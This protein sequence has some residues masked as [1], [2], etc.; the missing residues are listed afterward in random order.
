MQNRRKLSKV[1]LQDSTCLSEEVKIKPVR[2]KL[3]LCNKSKVNFG[4]QLRLACNEKNNKNVSSIFISCLKN[5]KCLIFFSSFSE[6][7]HFFFIITS[8]TQGSSDLPCRSGKRWWG[9][10]DIS[11][12]IFIKYFLFGVFKKGR[13]KNPDKMTFWCL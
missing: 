11:S 7:C 5:S 12:E 6:I 13:Y 8:K 9:T 3:G 1:I 10:Y 2:F 4:L